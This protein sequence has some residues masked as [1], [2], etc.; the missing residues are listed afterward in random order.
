MCSKAVEGKVRK[1][2]LFYPS[3]NIEQEKVQCL[4]RMKKK[5]TKNNAW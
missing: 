3:L 5:T 1:Q 4:Q 2:V